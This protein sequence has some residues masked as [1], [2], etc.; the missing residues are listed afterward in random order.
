MKIKYRTRD[1]LVSAGIISTPF[2]RTVDSSQ[3]PS[4]QN[5]STQDS[6]NSQ[7]LDSSQI[8]QPRSS[9]ISSQVK[10]YTMVG[11]IAFVFTVWRV[12]NGSL[13]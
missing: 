4:S 6:L 12:I 8:D 13:I 3:L 5:L 2:S 11:S 7:I 9:Q 1:Q 10:Q